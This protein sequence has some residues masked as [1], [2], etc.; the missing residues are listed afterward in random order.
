MPAS[1]TTENKIEDWGQDLHNTNE[2][3][4]TAEGAAVEVRSGEREHKDDELKEGW[5][6]S[7]KRKSDRVVNIGS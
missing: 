7:T 2:C 1:S 5:R 4:T 3:H 6:S